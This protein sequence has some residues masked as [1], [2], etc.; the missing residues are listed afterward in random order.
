M[1]IYRIVNQ[2]TIKEIDSSEL[3]PPKNRI[4]LILITVCIS[5]HL[6]NPV[7]A[8][9]DIT[10]EDLEITKKVIEKRVVN[11]F[12][13]RWWNQPMKKELE[14]RIIKQYLSQVTPSFKKKDNLRTVLPESDYY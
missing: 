3:I 6:S 4:D 10:H 8:N 9:R 14:K 2:N 1:K 11:E 5:K 13:Q 7:S 12:L